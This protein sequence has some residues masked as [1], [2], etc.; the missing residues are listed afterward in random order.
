MGKHPMST[1]LLVFFAA[2][3]SGLL[4]MCRAIAGV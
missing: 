4:D 1:L 3:W 2:V